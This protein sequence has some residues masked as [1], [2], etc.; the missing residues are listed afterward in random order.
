MLG[1]KGNP[2]WVFLSSPEEALLAPTLLRNGAA[3][4][5]S[6]S[7]SYLRSFTS[8]RRVVSS[9]LRLRRD[10]LALFLFLSNLKLKKGVTNPIW[11]LPVLL[12]G[13]DLPQCI[14]LLVSNLLDIDSE[15]ANYYNI[16]VFIFIL[17]ELLSG[18]IEIVLTID[19][20]WSPIYLWFCSRDSWGSSQ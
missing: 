1:K 5:F 3:I 15:P 7:H 12:A 11:H 10:F 13:E 4:F 20:V 14:H 17:F 18:S 16:T 2:N 9:A 8:S 19:S 6:L